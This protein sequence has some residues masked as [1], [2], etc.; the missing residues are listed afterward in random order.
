MWPVKAHLCGLRSLDPIWTVRTGSL[1]LLEVASEE[2]FI[3]DGMKFLVK[4]F[5]QFGS[6]AGVRNCQACTIGTSHGGGR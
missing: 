4:D 2:L 3:E 6:N 5:D 1:F